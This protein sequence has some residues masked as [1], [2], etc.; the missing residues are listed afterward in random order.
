MKSFF[1]W[2][3]K[4]AALSFFFATELVCLIISVVVWLNFLFT[5]D[6]N[7]VSLNQSEV[8]DITIIPEA[9]Q[10]DFAKKELGV[11]ALSQ[12]ITYKFFSGSKEMAIDEFKKNENSILILSKPLDQEEIAGLPPNRLPLEQEIIYQE[13]NS[14]RT[15]HVLIQDHSVNGKEEKI[16]KLLNLGKRQ[17]LVFEKVDQNSG[18]SPVR[19]S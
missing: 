14:D 17:N 3:G 11:I 5:K 18:K 7:Q 19:N 1:Q 10:L 13:S 15:T 12:G 9:S 8:P 16:A 4:N 6:N 2:V